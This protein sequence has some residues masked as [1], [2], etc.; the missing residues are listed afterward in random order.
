MKKIGNA[1]LFGKI[2]DCMFIDK[3]K[4][5]SVLTDR[6][7]YDDY[8][9][10][11]I[12]DFFFDDMHRPVFQL[13]IA[14]ATDV[15]GDYYESLVYIQMCLD[16]AFRKGVVFD[17]ALEGMIVPIKIDCDIPEDKQPHLYKCELDVIDGAWTFVVKG[18]DVIQ[19]ETAN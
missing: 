3:S 18:S 17:A 19:M 1:C 16:P 4:S 15:L 14:N 2:K 11:F 13:Q 7:D 5:F 9:Y 6:K 8:N 12:G 10:L